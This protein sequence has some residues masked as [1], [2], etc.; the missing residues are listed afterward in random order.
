MINKISQK[1]FIKIK[2]KIKQIKKYRI[3]YYMKKKLKIYIRII[4][5]IMHLLI[6]K[7][8]HKNRKI[9]HQKVINQRIKILRNLNKDNHW[10]IT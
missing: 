10:D 5:F 4:N 1:K 9:H 2:N 7:E 6:T 3:I 8:I